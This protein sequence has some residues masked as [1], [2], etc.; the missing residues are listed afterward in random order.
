M[1]IETFGR[2]CMGNITGYRIVDGTGPT[3]RVMA[4]FVGDIY[5]PGSFA[6]AK[7]EAEAKLAELEKEKA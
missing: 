1:H 7:A 5:V 4:S 2:D 3:W 6:K